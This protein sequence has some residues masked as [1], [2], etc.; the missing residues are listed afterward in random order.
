M[1]RKVEKEVRAQEHKNTSA[2]EHKAQEHKDR[3]F[4][5]R[6]YTL[7]TCALIKGGNVMSKY[8]VAAGLLSRYFVVA[9]LM[10]T[11]ASSAL[12][13]G[14]N[15]PWGT[16]DVSV[17]VAVQTGD[18]VSAWA[19]GGT[20]EQRNDM[21]GN[22]T[23]FFTATNV[24]TAVGD[25]TYQ[26]RVDLIPNAIYNYLFSARLNANMAGFTTGYSQSEPIPNSG[27]DSGTFISLS[28]TTVNQ[29][30]SGSISY[31]SIGGDAR[32]RLLMPDVAPGTTV[33]IFNNFAST[34]TGVANYSIVPGSNFLDLKWQGG[35][36]SWGANAPALDVLGGRHRIFVSTSLVGGTYSLLADLT[37]STTFY[38]HAGLTTGTSY[39]YIFVSSDAYRGITN[40]AAKTLWANLRRL[41]PAEGAVWNADEHVSNDKWGKPAL[42]VPV[43]FRVENISEEYSTCGSIVYLTPEGVDG[44][45]WPY[46]MPGLLV[47]GYV[48]KS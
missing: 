12:Y 23:S 19:G 40:P 9:I 39:Y 13:A 28:S 46:K 8:F 37:G 30:G 26:I 4:D 2:Q 43:W 44:R 48:P 35:L 33:H 45:F 36:G 31:V 3:G 41:T 6:T 1:N 18:V 7:S 24:M 22:A 5:L 20:G 25:G 11:V 21:T 27:S 10:M 17:G 34:P 14:A 15:A 16:S 38:R 47:V 42:P 32:R 29:P